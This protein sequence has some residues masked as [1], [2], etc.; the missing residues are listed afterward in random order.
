VLYQRRS[1][2]PILK[3]GAD[4]LVRVRLTCQWTAPCVGALGAF[5]QRLAADAESDFTVPAGKTR[6]VL[7]TVCDRRSTCAD[8][9]FVQ[10]E[11]RPGARIPVLIEI[12]ADLSN[13]QVVP[14]GPR[15]TVPGL[16]VVHGR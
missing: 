6:T 5:D 12:F 3:A 16:L 11:L 7:I 14:A 1:A 15:Y 13:G 9:R 8:R 4:G 2:G 10:G